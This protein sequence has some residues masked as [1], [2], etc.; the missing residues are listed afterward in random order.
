MLHV[1]RKHDISSGMDL[2]IPQIDI[3]KIDEE[4]PDLSSSRRPRSQSFY[5]SKHGKNLEE[6]EVSEPDSSRPRSKSF[7]TSETLQRYHLGAFSRSNALKPRTF[8][9]LNADGK[10][11][12]L[13]LKRSKTDPSSKSNASKDLEDKTTDNREKNL[14]PEMEYGQFVDWVKIDPVSAMIYQKIL[15]SDHKQLKGMARAGCWSRT[16]TLRAKAYH[17]II[18]SI[19][20]RSITPDREVYQQLSGELFGEHKVSTHPL[21]DYMGDS[22]IPIYCLNKAGLNSVK[23][24]L[25]CIGSHFPDITFCPVLPALVSLLLH[26]SV[27]EAECFHSICRLIAYNDPARHFLDQTFLSYRAS[28]MTFGDLANKFCNSGHKLITTSNQ[29]FFDA[30]SDWITWIFGGGLPFEYATRVLDV[31][32]LEGYKVLYRVALTLLAEYKVAV[33][34]KASHNG[35]I[36]LDINSFLENITHHITVDKLLEKAFNI[37]LSQKKIDLLL[38]ANKSTLMQKGITIHQRRQ[39]VHIAVDFDSFGSSI[40]TGQEMR[41]VWS[42]IPERFALLYPIMLF[43][44]REHGR[45]LSSFYSHVECFEPTVL[46]IRTEEGEVCGAFLS[47]DWSERNKPGSRGT[48]LFFGTGE[49]FVFTL[50]PDTER[51]EWAFLHMTDIAKE[52]LPL[53]SLPSLSPSPPPPEVTLTCPDGTTQDPSYHFPPSPVLTEMPPPSLTPKVPE[54]HPLSA[55]MFMAGGKERIIIGGGGGQALCIEADLLNGRTERCDTFE[56]SPLCREHFKIQCLEVWGIQ[57]STKF[58]SASSKQSV[59]YI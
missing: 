45:S 2:D 16:H 59:D 25:L 53:S 37:H 12:R 20:C 32:L 6:D 46:L 15:K 3:L 18:H 29:S 47:S 58:T 21:P 44:T 31:Y 55:S 33:A 11:S 49:C 27:D 5:N 22:F 38:A 30:Y 19:N 17:H 52:D 48:R 50:H 23:K 34:S 43:S 10:L 40:V 13:N 41:I 26:Y 35:D 57:S 8:S 28:C 24:I 1:P 54:Q 7:Y 36:S 14:S 42:W 9:F 56:N 39:S 4:L 51:Y